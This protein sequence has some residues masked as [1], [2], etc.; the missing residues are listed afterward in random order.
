MKIVSCRAQ[1]TLC[2]AVASWH[3]FIHLLHLMSFLVLLVTIFSIVFDLISGYLQ[4]IHTGV[5]G[6]RSISHD[7][8]RSLEM[9]NYRTIILFGFHIATPD[10]QH[11]QVQM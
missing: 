8:K 7:N 5:R 4:Y 9:V 6:E 2:R 3:G 10:Q 1:T 11:R